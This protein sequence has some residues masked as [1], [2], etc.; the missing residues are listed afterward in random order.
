MLIAGDDATLAAPE[1]QCRRRGAREEENG[2]KRE[3]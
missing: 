1:V 2:G 3:Q